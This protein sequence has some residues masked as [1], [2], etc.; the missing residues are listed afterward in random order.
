MIYEKTFLYKNKK[1]K[2]KKLPKRASTDQTV[3]EQIN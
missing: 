1:N 3:I 2:D